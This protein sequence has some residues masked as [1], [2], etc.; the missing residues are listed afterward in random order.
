MN[1]EIEIFEKS[2]KEPFEIGKY[3]G[4]WYPTKHGYDKK[5]T[6]IYGQGYVNIPVKTRKEIE[7]LIIGDNPA[8]A[9]IKFYKEYGKDVLLYAIGRENISDCCNIKAMSQLK[10]LINYSDGFFEY[11]D[12]VQIINDKIEAAV[13][14]KWG[15]VIKDEW[16]NLLEGRN[17]LGTGTCSFRKNILLHVSTSIF[18]YAMSP[19]IDWL[20]YESFLD[21]FILNF[22]PKGYYKTDEELLMVME[23]LDNESV[24]NKLEYV[25]SK[26][27]IDLI[28]ELADEKKRKRK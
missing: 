17:Q 5:K 18:I 3:K 1:K 14:E 8:E 2:R 27:V 26:E 9:V 25:S 16:I 24:S 6:F 22:T 23:G 11:F 20:S 13:L 4:A 21:N 28:N 7:P 19:H 10:S 12:K 15:V